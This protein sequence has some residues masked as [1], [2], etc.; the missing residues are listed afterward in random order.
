[1]LIRK[2]LVKKE[3]LLYISVD[4]KS[5]LYYFKFKT[6]DFYKNNITKGTAFLHFAVS[7]DTFKKM[8]KE[9]KIEAYNAFFIEQLPTLLKQIK[10]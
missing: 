1:M 3:D 5:E 2:E 8:L 6:I 10:P 7:T 4:S 9:K